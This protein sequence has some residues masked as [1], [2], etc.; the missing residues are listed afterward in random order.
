M[1]SMFDI[2]IHLLR[3]VMGFSS[4]KNFCFQ[5]QEPVKRYVSYAIFAFMFVRSS[6]SF[7]RLITTV[8]E[9]QCLVPTFIEPL[10]RH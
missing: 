6:T 9:A 8:F 5:I 3:V 10:I 2:C 4:A 7:C 1:E